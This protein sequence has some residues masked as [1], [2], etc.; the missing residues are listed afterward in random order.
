M[1]NPPSFRQLEQATFVSPQL[2]TEHLSLLSELGI[3]TVICQRPDEEI[4]SEISH[5]TPY[6]D[7]MA[8]LLR[9]EGIQLIYQPLYTISMI[10][11]DALSKHLKTADFPLLIYCASGTRSTILWALTQILIEKR[12]K[13]DIVAKAEKAGYFIAQ[14]LP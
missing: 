2:T 8:E 3:K 13:T 5:L 4:S 7:S 10:E 6:H 12:K 11:V 1:I 9:T 14:Y